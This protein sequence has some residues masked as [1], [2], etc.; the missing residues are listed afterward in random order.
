MIVLY[1]CVSSGSS[2]VYLSVVVVERTGWVLGLCEMG[3][4]LESDQT[5]DHDTAHNKVSNLYN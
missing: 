1:D 3:N 5:D 4:G 2:N